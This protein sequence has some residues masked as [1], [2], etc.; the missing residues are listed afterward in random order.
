MVPFS[1]SQR[2]RGRNTH[3]QEDWV[4]RVT[5]GVLM[6]RRVERT[7]EAVPVPHLHSGLHG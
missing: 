6:T 7:P 3:Q 1:L 2:E 5:G 4:G